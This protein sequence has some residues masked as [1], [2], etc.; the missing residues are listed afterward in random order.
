MELKKTGCLSIVFMFLLRSSGQKLSKLLGADMNPD[1]DQ[2][3]IRNIR[4]VLLWEIL[5]YAQY[6]TRENDLNEK[7]LT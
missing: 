3:R 5:N 7:L 4:E 2:R 6:L 1:D